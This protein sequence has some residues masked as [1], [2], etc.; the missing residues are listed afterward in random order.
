[1]YKPVGMSVRSI[2]CNI[3]GDDRSARRSI[4]AEEAVSYCGKGFFERFTI[5]TFINVNDVIESIGKNMEKR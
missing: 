2:G 3:T 4:P 5:R 1:M